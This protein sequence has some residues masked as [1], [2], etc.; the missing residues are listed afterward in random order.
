MRSF[1]GLMMPAHAG[2]ELSALLAPLSRFSDVLRLGDPANFH[3]TL[4]FLGDLDRRQVAAAADLPARLEGVKWPL[5]ISTGAPAGHPAR[6]PRVLLAG[7]SQGSDQLVDLHARTAT[8]L[9]A[10]DLPL[11]TGP[12]RPHITLARL[13]PRANRS[14][15]S[16][17]SAAF[18]ESLAGES[19]SF[20]VQRLELVASRLTSRGPIYQ[21]VRPPG[22]VRPGCGP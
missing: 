1:L 9:A 5:E 21:I 15:R 14:Q 19:I 10:A 4:A 8:A 20:Q 17:I 12:Y 11:P 3:I 13:R 22:A 18:A 7:I 16:N 2:R 6:R